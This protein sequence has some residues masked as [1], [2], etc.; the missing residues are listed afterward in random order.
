MPKEDGC[1]TGPRP[2]L[3]TLS[4]RIRVHARGSCNCHA[5]RAPCSHARLHCQGKLSA[6]KPGARSLRPGEG[7]GA[8]AWHETC[9]RE[10]LT[11]A[12][13][14]VSSEFV[15]IPF[16]RQKGFIGSCE[17][18]SLSDGAFLP[19]RCIF[20]SCEDSILHAER[21]HRTWFA[22]VLF[23]LLSRGGVIKSSMGWPNKNRRASLKGN[24]SE[25]TGKMLCWSVR[26]YR[27]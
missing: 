21:N 3:W 19:A 8:P 20:G 18:V 1:T 12:C 16:C 4:C 5:A 23:A 26:C 25:L 6:A 9:N 27:T 2:H 15:K 24:A 7:C 14:K 17:H 22:H 10:C 13:E 11:S